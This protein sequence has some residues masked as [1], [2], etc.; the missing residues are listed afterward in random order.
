MSKSHPHLVDSFDKDR[1][2][3]AASEAYEERLWWRCPNSDDH[4]WE[5]SVAHRAAGRGCPFCAGQR[6]SSTNSLQT[7]HPNIA[8]QWHPTRN[9]DL[10]PADVTFGSNRR[11]WWQCPIADDHTW[12]A[13]VSERRRGSG[14]PYCAGH[15]VAA[16]NSLRTTHPDAASQ[17]H[18]TRNGALTPD[19]VTFGTNQQAWWQ[20]PIADDHTW[21]ARISQLTRGNGCPFCAGRKTA[22]SNSMATTHP[23]LAAQWHPD[24]NGDLTP[25]D[26][27]AG[28]NKPIWWACDVALDHEW[29]AAGCDRAAGAGCPYCAGQRVTT[30]NAFGTTHPD[31][32]SQW[33]PTRNG[34]LTEL[35]I[36]AGSNV[37]AWWQC[38]AAA[39]HQ[40]QAVVSSRAAGARCPFCTHQRVCLSNSMATTHPDMATQWHPTLNG[41]VTPET[42][43]AGTNKK[44]WWAC[45]VADDHI[46]ESSGSTR[47]RSWDRKPGSG[48]PFCANK[49]VCLSNSMATTHPHL[50]LLFDNE[51]NN[52]LTTE[53]VIATTNQ[54][55]WWR[56]R[57][58]DDHIWEKSG[59]Q[60]VKYQTMGCPYC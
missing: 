33:H 42:V 43:T 11:V 38:D 16:S 32:A 22:A 18:P 3:C 30:S 56:C 7:I 24:R 55:L 19:D 10:T 25:N 34:D 53:T 8:A 23:T 44:I 17:W 48:C 31:A 41:H 1:N 20:C 15:K 47:K 52:G 13:T 21:Q 50:A 35:D 5:A 29:Q 36:T 37:K 4:L 12:D 28:T 49:R 26:V 27:V 39:D 14:C 2:G 9:G 60:T 58:G 54:K 6:T 51:L 57:A 46:W 40:W 59:A 45:P